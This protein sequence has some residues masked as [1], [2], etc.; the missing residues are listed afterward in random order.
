MA[1]ALP[2]PHPDSLLK[3]SMTIRPPGQPRAMSLCRRCLKAFR[4]LGD[5]YL[6][7]TVRPPQV[8]ETL[9]RLGYTASDARRY[10]WDLRRFRIKEVLRRWLSRATST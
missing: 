8:R 3:F 6:A 5:G 2:C 1:G 10:L 9:V 7:G 4:T